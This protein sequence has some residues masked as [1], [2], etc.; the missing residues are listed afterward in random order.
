MEQI[1]HDALAEL[2]L[3][4]LRKAGEMATADEKITV[5]FI[6][7][8]DSTQVLTASVAAAATP[9]YLVEQMLQAGFIPVLAQSGRYKLRTGDGVQLL[10]NVPLAQAGIADGAT[11]EVN[12]SMT[13]ARG[14]HAGGAARC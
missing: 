4:A 11:L 5:H 3:G 14:R 7:P 8:T 13:G 2:G 6:H 12:P 9:V 1:G 10:D